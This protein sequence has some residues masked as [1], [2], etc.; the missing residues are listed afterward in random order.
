MN[1]SGFDYY[2]PLEIAKKN[3]KISGLQNNFSEMKDVVTLNL[4]I[5]NHFFI[6]PI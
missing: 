2:E 3:L 5:K 6:Q 1:I 4:K